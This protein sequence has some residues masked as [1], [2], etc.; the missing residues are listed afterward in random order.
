MNKANLASLTD[1]K[2]FFFLIILVLF[3]G[4]I[5]SSVGYFLVVMIYGV[6]ALNWISSIDINPDSIG[7]LKIVQ[8]VQSVGMF[9]AP[10]F[11]LAYLYSSEPKRYLGFKA[12]SFKNYLLVIFTMLVCLP[13]INLLSSLNELIPLA[14]WMEVME[15]NAEKLTKAFLTTDSFLVFFLNLFMIAVLPAL[16]EELIFR[17][18]IQKHF[19]A[20]TKSKVWGILIAAFLFSL[21][22]F[23]FK[24]FIPRFALGVMF[25]FMYAWSGSIWLPMVAHFT[26]NAIATIGFTLMGSGAVDSKVE[27]VGGLTYLWPLGIISI[28]AVSILLMKLKELNSEVEIN[29]LSGDI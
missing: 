3:S 26:N 28:V 5:F 19:S 22:H 14:N 20:I 13:G 10:A 25:G 21:F 1:G 29:E 8:I 4:I 27:D 16:G 2:K 11:L 9:V 6:G 17:G 15:A 24:G 12:K 23:Q 18:L 7:A